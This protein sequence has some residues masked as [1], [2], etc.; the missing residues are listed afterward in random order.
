MAKT[1][2][3]VAKLTFWYREFEHFCN[4]PLPCH[5]LFKWSLMVEVIYS[6]MRQNNE[7]LWVCENIYHSTL[8]KIEK[9]NFFLFS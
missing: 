3:E 9:F 8:G 4:I 1:D 5:I 7:E 6:F 2:S